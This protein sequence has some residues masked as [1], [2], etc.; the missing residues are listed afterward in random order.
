M[1]QTLPRSPRS[2]YANIVGLGMLRGALRMP[3]EHPFDAV[4]TYW[5]NDPSLSN[6]RTAA[7]RLYREYGW[8]GF[9]SG[10]LPAMVRFTT[11]DMYR[12]PLMI[13]L[14]PVWERLC[15]RAFH[16]SHRVG[17]E[18]TRERGAA[19]QW[20]L[21][22]P[23]FEFESESSTQMA[24]RQTARALTGLS[25]A[26]VECVATCPLEVLKVKLITRHSASSA[27]VVNTIIGPRPSMAGPR[28]HSVDTGT[29]LE[30][31][32]GTSSSS[33]SST[34][35]AANTIGNTTTGNGSGPIRPVGGN[36]SGPIGTTAAPQAA[37]RLVPVPLMKGSDPSA[38]SSSSISN[39]ANRAFVSQSVGQQSRQSFA[40]GAPVHRVSAGKGLL[41]GLG[42]YYLR[43]NLSWLSFLCCD[44][45]FKHLARVL[46]DTPDG[47]CLSFP[48]LMGAAFLVGVVNTTLIMP[49]D[50]AKT[51]LQQFRPPPKPT[52]PRRVGGYGWQ[53]SRRDRTTPLT[54]RAAVT[55]RYRSHGVRGLYVGFQI[56]V[57]HYIVNSVF[58]VVM[59]EHLEQKYVAT[60]R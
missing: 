25:I 46:S 15:L 35:R 34:R 6:A 13:Y 31:H 54:T 53:Q 10:G 27:E 45:Y 55:A 30:R 2:E 43:Q 48:W 49:F 32:G 51:Q 39:P 11:K 44:G 7:A 20:E 21:W 23:R 37:P 3:F 52:A 14:L 26:H 29:T 16:P 41:Q 19:P 42:A 4:K 36:G 40:G 50:S 47:E 18:S 1:T 12:W 22:P 5:Q 38:S 58:T 24:A 9:Y 33:S 59:L 56:R 28:S 60:K 17:P 57:T 8:R